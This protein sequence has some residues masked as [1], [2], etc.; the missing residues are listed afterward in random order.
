MKHMCTTCTKRGKLWHFTD[1]IEIP[2]FFAM[3]A[4][5]R[6]KGKNQR[7]KLDYIIGFASIK[8]N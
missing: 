1:K 8:L 4:K 6:V 5:S 2:R 3:F 7:S